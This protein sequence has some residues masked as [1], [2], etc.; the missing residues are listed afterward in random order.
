MAATKSPENKTGVLSILAPEGLRNYESLLLSGPANALVFSRKD[1]VLLENRDGLFSLSLSADGAFI[2][3][4][5]KERLLC[6]ISDISVHPYEFFEHVTTHAPDRRAQKFG[7]AYLVTLFGNKLEKKAGQLKGIDA[8][9][10]DMINLKQEIEWLRR[11]T[12]AILA[13]NSFLRS[14]S[15]ADLARSAI[16]KFARRAELECISTIMREEPHE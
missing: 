15:E 9:D 3:Q 6:T 1:K 5:G 16:V 8:S 2:L 11:L 14:T 10:P 4:H 12:R 7:L 13:Q